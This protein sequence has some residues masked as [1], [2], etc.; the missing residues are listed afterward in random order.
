LHK[1]YIKTLHIYLEISICVIL[2][3]K[4]KYMIIL[5]SLLI[6]FYLLFSKGIFVKLTKT[7]F[8]IIFGI[9]IIY[10][11]A[12]IGD[13]IYKVVSPDDYKQTQIKIEQE[14]QQQQLEREKE[15]QIQKELQQIYNN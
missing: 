5:T 11:I 2:S 6:C 12:L 7:L 10:G 15:K 4:L 14:N 3:F 8:F 13:K 9:F 1:K